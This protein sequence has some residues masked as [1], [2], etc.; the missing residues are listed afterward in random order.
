MSTIPIGFPKT[1]A[2]WRSEKFICIETLSGVPGLMYQEDKPYRVFLDLDATNA[3]IGRALLMALDKSRYVDNSEPEFFDPT[4]AVR[5]V[6]DWEKDI[7]Q[8]YGFKS[9]HDVYKNLDWCAGQMFDGKIKIQPHRRSPPAWRNLPAEKTV[10][11]P[12]T[13]DA[14]TIGAALRLALSRCE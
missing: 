4:R 1:T 7:M 2:I 6:E 3:L 11:I 5:V 12:M 13:D 14:A 8:R 9:E 10:F